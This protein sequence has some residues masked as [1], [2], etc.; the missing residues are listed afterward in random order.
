MLEQAEVASQSPPGWAQNPGRWAGALI[1]ALAIWDPAAAN[2]A[3]GKEDRV[4][5][6]GSYPVEARAAD[7]VAAKERAIIEGQQAAFRSLLKRIVPVSAYHRLARL[8]MLRAAD[9]IDGVSVR[10][11]R[12]SS[13]E[14]IATYDFVFQA[15]AVRRLLDQESVPFLDRQAPQITLI[16]VYLAPKA[17]GPTEAPDDARGSDVWLYAWKGLDLA[18]S[19][20]PVTLK[21]LARGVS[22]E[23]LQALAAGDAGALRR[24]G[25]PRTETLVVALLE[26]DLAQKRLQVT[27]AGRDAVAS[28]NLRRQYRLEGVDLSYTAELAAVISLGI[29]EG[30]WK[31]INIRDG[32]AINAAAPAR[33]P[34]PRFPSVPAPVFSPPG[35]PAPSPQPRP[36]PRLRS[37]PA[38]Q[39]D[40]VVRIAIEFQSMTEWQEISRKIG[41]L[42]E[43]S[44]LDVQGLSGRGARVSL[45]YPGG[46]QKLASALAQQG[47]VLRQAASGWLLTQR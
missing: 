38:E 7:A 27:L 15:E 35:V 31:A 44:D 46:G 19:L 41:A 26:P 1:V 20:T 43:V 16:P 33:V 10:S 25:E 45:R 34:G 36:E 13:T 23:T 24:I 5:T 30:R 39:G 42:P 8:K 28:L 4:Y 32:G 12:N 9:L 47:L 2:A 40:G 29:L 14:Y 6:I 3:A 11:E 21:S 17:A 22:A 37:E 18:N